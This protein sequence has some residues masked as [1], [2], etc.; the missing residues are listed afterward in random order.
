[1]SEAASGEA[2]STASVFRE[3]YRT[4][5]WGVGSGPGSTPVSTQL[6]RHVLADL[7]SR[8]DI[9]SVVDVGCGDWAYSRFIDWGRAD[10]LGIDVVDTLIV[11]NTRRYAR[12]GVRFECVDVLLHDI[13]P[14]DL[15]ICKDVLQHWPNDSIVDFCRGTASRYPFVLLT[16]D[17]SSPS[18]VDEDLNSDVEMGGWRTLDLEAP[19]F[20][21]TAAWSVDYV[22]PGEETKRISLF[23]H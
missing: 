16:N 7:L 17:I 22:I 2:D 4:A 3:V 13:S 20:G 18:L 21:L 23:T 8:H 15:L 14:V 1:M 5:T 6:Y 10:Y 19:P 9:G 12:A 11:E